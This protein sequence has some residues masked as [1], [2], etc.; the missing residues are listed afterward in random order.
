MYQRLFGLVVF[1][2][3]FYLLSRRTRESF[4]EVE[5]HRGGPKTSSL[6]TDPIKKYDNIENHPE[7]RHNSTFLVSSAAPLK[8]D[9]KNLKKED[10][11]GWPLYFNYY[12]NHN[13]LTP[14]RDQKQCGSCWAF[15]VSEMFSD[16]IKIATNG[17]F[18]KNLS[19]QFITSCFNGENLA[20]C[21]GGLPDTVIEAMGQQ[22]VPLDEKYPYQ[23]NKPDPDSSCDNGGNTCPCNPPD[24]AGCMIKAIPGSLH[25]VCDQEGFQNLNEWDQISQETITKNVVRMKHEIMKNGPIVATIIVYSDFYDYKSGQIYEHRPGSQIVGGH[26][27]VIVGWQDKE[28]GIPIPYWICKNSYSAN[29]GDE[30]YMMIKMGENESLI[31]SN[32]SGGFP[33]MTASCIEEHN[34]DKSL[35]FEDMMKK[36]FKEWLDIHPHVKWNVDKLP[37]Y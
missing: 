17:G 29:F 13:L 30:G 3:I 24:P 31:E 20:G 6:L 19:V 36:R 23:Q 11:E 16:R 25:K 8:D 18:N 10:A 22:G 27:I 2:L 9:L 35:K 37:I 32:C 21:G 7:Y 12:H 26:A 1:F 28:P 33:D 14:V 34:P 4:I 15:A 5:Q